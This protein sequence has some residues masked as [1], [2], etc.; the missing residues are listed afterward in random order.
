MLIERRSIKEIDRAAYNPR[1]DL[2]PGDEEYQQLH[3]SLHEYGLLIPLVLN[4]RTNR[5]V[6]G[7][8]RLTVLEN[9]GETE[10]DFSIVDLDDISEKQLNIAL[11]KAQGAWDDGKQAELLG[12]LEDRAIETGFSLPEIE[13]LQSRIEDALDTEF[14]DSELEAIEATFNVTIDFPVELKD[15]VNGYIRE[16]SKQPLIDAMIEAARRE[17]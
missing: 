2:Q 9:S 10:A 7:H 14:L 5:L 12:S 8:Q 1:V 13:G 3:D 4:K 6:G 16:N 11:N 17:E 15:E